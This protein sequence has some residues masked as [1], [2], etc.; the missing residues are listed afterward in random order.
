MTIFA[1]EAAGIQGQVEMWKG[2]LYGSVFHY[3]NTTLR[4]LFFHK[5]AIYIEVTLCG[6]EIN[7]VL[8]YIL[9]CSICLKKKYCKTV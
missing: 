3:T 7:V 8:K 5:E 1:G 2:K 6:F 9:K 4:N